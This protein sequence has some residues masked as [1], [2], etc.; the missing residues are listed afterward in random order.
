MKAQ[1]SYYSYRKPL[2]KMLNSQST[3]VAIIDDDEDDYF[4]ISDYISSIDGSE[5]IIDWCNN[6]ENAIQKIRAKEYDIYLVDYR[7][8]KHTGLELLQEARAAG[9]DDPIILLTGKGSKDID[10]KAMESGAT[11]YLV[12]SELNTEKLERCIRYSLDRADAVRELKAR[13]N[14]YRNLFEGSKDAVFIADHQL[15]FNE[16]NEAASEL[17]GKPT[18]ALV[19]DYFCQF[20]RSGPQKEKFQQLFDRKEDIRDLEIDIESGRETRSCQVSLSFLESSNGHPLVH[21]IL[22]DITHI[23]KAEMANLQ[24]QKLAANERLMRILAHEIRNPL[25]NISLSV[26]H[27]DMMDE[28]DPEME[29]NLIDIIKR[30]CTRINHIITELLNLTR[31]PELSFETHNLQEILDECIDMNADRL[32]LQKIAVQK[33]YTADPLSILADKSKLILAFSNI[34]VNAIEA[35]EISKGEL[36]ISVSN[37]NGGC[38]VSIR[39]NGNGIPEEYLPKL[40]EPFFTLKKNGIG[41]GLAASYSI[42]QS[43]NAS[44]RVESKVNKGT[45]FVISFAKA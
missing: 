36:V 43:H 34:M 15:H 35:M 6:Y 10:I 17:F 2:T 39:D 3:R 7:L 25:N 42:I 27:F 5:F 1:D 45:E 24:A 12:K 14:R 13:E 20:I 41:L 18:S 40:F 32:D 28:D 31:P 21:G 9:V 26:D 37:S 8:G 29:K 33:K 44:V 38:H 11:D 23:K 4:I 19:N 30:N 22:H 16:V